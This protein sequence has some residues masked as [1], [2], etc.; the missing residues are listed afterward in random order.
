MKLK[1]LLRK[2]LTPIKKV[3]IKQG[4]QELAFDTVGDEYRLKGFFDYKVDYFEIGCFDDYFILTVWV[5]KEI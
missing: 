3:S 5:K 2:N 1:K 4:N